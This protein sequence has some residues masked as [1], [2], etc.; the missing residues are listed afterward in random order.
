MARSRDPEADLRAR[1]AAARALGDLGDPRFE[2]RRGP[3]G[4]HLLPPLVPI[5]GGE[6]PLGSDEGLYQD[7]APAHTV[8]LAP[9]AIGRFAVTNAEWRCFLDAS[10]YEDE[11]WWDTEAGRRWRRGE[12]TAE[13]PKQQWRDNRRFLQDN[14]NWIGKALAEARITFKQA[15]GWESYRTMTDAEFEALLHSWYPPGRQIRPAYWDDPAYKHPAQ[16]VVGLSW[17]EALAYCAWLSAQ[18][19]IDLGGHAF[20]LPTEAQWE[21]AA[22]GREGRI[23]PWGAEFD[24][25]RCNTFRPPDLIDYAMRPVRRP[26]AARCLERA[27][28]YG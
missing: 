17:H 15:E 19:L 21:A 8:T 27:A 4:D 18:T 16:P 20:R 6:Y 12:D 14:P 9:Y 11:R 13:G 7:E 25:A 5:E 24:P 22:R 28:R 2:R 23:Y 26:G 10:G 1:I 3:D